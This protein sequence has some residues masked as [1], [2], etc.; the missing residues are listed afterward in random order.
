MGKDKR[1][2]AEIQEMSKELEERLANLL[3]SLMVRPQTCF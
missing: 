2:E 3:W 1:K